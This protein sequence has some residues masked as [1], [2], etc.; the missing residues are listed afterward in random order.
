[1]RPVCRIKR[2]QSQNSEGDTDVKTEKV[3]MV[4]PDVI[5]HC[6]SN[7][8]APSVVIERVSAISV[9]VAL[10]YIVFSLKGFPATGSAE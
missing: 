6:L 3:Y 9:A 10:V 8:L 7:Q 4:R 1:M 5:G 2:S